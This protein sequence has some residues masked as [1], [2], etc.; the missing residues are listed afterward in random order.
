MI[1]L[2]YNKVRLHYI[3]IKYDYIANVNVTVP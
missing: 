3:T 2:Y 1:T